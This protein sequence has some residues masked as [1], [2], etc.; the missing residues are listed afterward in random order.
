[1]ELWEMKQ[2]INDAK[3]TIKAADDVAN[4]IAS[5]LPGRL[6]HVSVWTLAQLKK[7]LREFNAHTRRWKE[8]E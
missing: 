3:Q 8:S 1:M 5:I 4:S 2:A 7:E 6:R